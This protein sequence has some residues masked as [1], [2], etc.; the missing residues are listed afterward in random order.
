MPIDETMPE[1]D[2]TLAL[3]NMGKWAREAG[4]LLLRYFRGDGL[5]ISTKLN[6]SDIVTAA[7]KASETLLIDRIATAYPGHSILSEESG[8]HN[9]HSPYKWVIDPLD[10]TTNFSA[11]LPNFSI[12]IALQYNDETIAGIVYAPYL[13]EMF[14]AAKGGGATL[15]GKKLKPSE[16]TELYA[17]VVATG[18]PVDKDS[19]PDNNL[20]ATSRVLPAVRGLRRLGSAALDLSY[21]GAGFLDAYWEIN[22]Y[23][24]DIAAGELIA[25]E[26]GAAIS[27]FRHDRNMSILA[28]TK[29]IYDN[30]LELITGDSA[31]E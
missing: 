5:E 22:L 8:F 25:S 30:L 6:Q 16:K 1:F 26:S 12:S 24:W 11:G 15:N 4:R 7:D 21:V 19:N 14:Q 13:N 18:F 10:G 27:H 23:P 9:S 20:A 17:S 29:G 31:K 3:A 28:A 2:T